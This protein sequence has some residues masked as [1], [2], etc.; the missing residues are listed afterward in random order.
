M[1]STP[2]SPL[3]ARSGVSLLL[4]RPGTAVAATAGSAAWNGHA[5]RPGHCT[6]ALPTHTCTAPP[7]ASEP[8]SPQELPQK[9]ST[10]TSAAVSTTATP[11]GATPSRAA[12]CSTWSRDRCFP[13]EHPSSDTWLVSITRVRSLP[14]LCTYRS[15]VSHH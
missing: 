5:H 13:S 2:A 10:A 11:P 6:A 12:S 1:P 3:G 14:V 9:P 7:G 8:C 15:T 4:W